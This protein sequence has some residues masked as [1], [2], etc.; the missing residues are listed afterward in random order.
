[1]TFGLVHASFCLSGWRAVKLTLLTPWININFLL[2][3]PKNINTQPREKVMR[4]NKMI[5]QR[6]IL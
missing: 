6:K 2:T 4:T 1:M 5:T 3:R